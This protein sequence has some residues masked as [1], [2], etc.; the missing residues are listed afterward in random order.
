VGDFET[1]L[2]LHP[3]GHFVVKVIQ[4]V[5]DD[6]L[7]KGLTEEWVREMG[8]RADVDADDDLDLETTVELQYEVLVEIW[9]DALAEIP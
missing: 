6:E 7:G 3:E 4:A 9:E 2:S 1:L 5:L 8:E